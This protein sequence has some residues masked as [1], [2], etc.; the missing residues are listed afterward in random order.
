VSEQL[1]FGEVQ[2]FVFEILVCDID[3][4]PQYFLD[5][6]FYDGFPSMMLNEIRFAAFAESAKRSP[7]MPRRPRYAA[8]WS[9]F[10]D[11]LT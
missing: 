11:G 5:S 1:A 8:V 3:P 7:E 2:V 6:E 4:E 9:I 10:S